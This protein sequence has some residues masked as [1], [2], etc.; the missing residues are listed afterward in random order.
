MWDFRRGKG[1]PKVSVIMPCLNMIRYISDCLDSVTNQ[2]LH[3]IE[4]LVVDAGSTDGTVELVR[5]YMEN[6]S[7]I[8]LMHSEKRSYGYQVNLGIAAADGEF[9]TILDT[10]DRLKLDAYETMY[11]IAVETGADYVKGTAEMF[12]DFV[13]AVYWYAIMQFP[14]KEYGKNGKITICPM[15]NPRLLRSD[16][17]LWCGIY[18]KAFFKQVRL[19]ESPGADRKSVV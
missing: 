5:T 9:I 12:F 4:M 13:D 16:S 10:D 2:T 8:R 19:H 18:R 3:D 11:P 1:I 15:V 17:F 6:D 7:R 14:P